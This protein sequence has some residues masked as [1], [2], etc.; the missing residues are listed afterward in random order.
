MTRF[1]DILRDR[2]SHVW[3][4]EHR[5]P[6]VVELGDGTLPLE[7]FQWYMKQDYLYL[8]EFSRVIALA[9]AKPKPSKTWAGSPVCSTRR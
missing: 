7:K 9:V 3:E 2:A 5:H 8:I 4:Q 1:S 6:F